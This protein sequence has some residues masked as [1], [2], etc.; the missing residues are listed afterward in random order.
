MKSEYG[1]IVIYEEE[2]R[3]VEVRFDRDTVWLTQRQMAEL[4]DTST[5]NISLHL[6]KIYK[7]RELE[8]NPTTEDFSAV[9]KEGRRE[10]RR[11]LTHYN[12]DAIISVGYRINSKRG[13]RFRQWAT[14]V[15]KDHFIHGYTINE[16]RLAE[17]GLVE[18]EQAVDLLSKT[19]QNQE[20]VSDEGKAILN[21]IKKYAKSWTLLLLYDEQQLALPKK[22]N[23]AQSSLSYDQAQV[24]ISA[25]KADLAKKG[26]AT[27]LFGQ[28]R[29]DNLQ[30]VLGNINQTFGGEMLY[31]SAEEKAAHLLYFIIKD[32]PFVDGNKRIGS[33]LFLLFLK[34]NNLLNT[35]QLNDNGLVAL[36][37]LVA[38]SESR[39]K[40]LMVRLILNLL[41]G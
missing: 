19:L 29:D 1:E 10:V 24:A 32:H 16:R 22:K 12:L 37:L 33:F 41:E 13:V 27:D 40:E 34:E 14:S 28:E 20:M 36:A 38:E 26:E 39:Q 31:P 21:V 4:F 11:T 6:K 17:K 8:K 23:R 2:E 18:M 7:D 35:S 5:D 15:L 25:L 9:Q 30:G 3:S